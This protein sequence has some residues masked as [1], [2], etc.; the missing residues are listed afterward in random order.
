[1]STLSEW[2]LGL[3]AVVVPSLGEP[4]TTVYNG[5]VEGDYLYIAAAASGRISTVLVREGDTVATGATLFRLDDS[6]QT[7]NLRAAEAQVAVARANLANLQTGGR[8][9]EI[10]VIRASLDQAVADQHLSETTLERTRRL[11]TSGTISQARVDADQS[12]LDSANAR[13][14]QLQA[15]LQVAELPARDAQKIAAEA[16]IAAAEAQLEGARTALSDRVVDAPGSGTVDK[17]FF[18]AGEVAGAGAPVIAILPPDSLKALFFVPESDRTLVTIGAVF[19]VSCHGCPE[20]MEAR[21]TRLAS[22]PQFTPPIIYSRDESSRLVFQ[23]EADLTGTGGV[24][25]GQPVQ[26]SPKP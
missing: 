3:L 5:Y 1:M 10:E 6:A 18:T 16:S 23:A 20:G 8:A 26:L 22:S 4:E 2:L 9:E 25:P 15:Q 14:A 11:F 17:V 24:L 7:A 12:K 21:V 19:D 13:V